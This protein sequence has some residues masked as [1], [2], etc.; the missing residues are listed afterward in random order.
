MRQI[1]KNNQNKEHCLLCNKKNTENSH[2][3]QIDR[4]H[5]KFK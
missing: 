4:K 1:A 2:L 5:C 3:E